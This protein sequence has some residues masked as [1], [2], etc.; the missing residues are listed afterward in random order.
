MYAYNASPAQVSFVKKLLAER[1]VSG[2]N[3]AYAKR[4]TE[5]LRGEGEPLTKAGAH[6]L[7]EGLLTLPKLGGDTEVQTDTPDVP[8]GFYAVRGTDPEAVNDIQF[9]TIDK[10]TEG[11]WAGYTFV[12][13]VVG[14][15]EIRI[16][17]SRQDAAVAAIAK[18][19]KAASILYGHEIGRCGLCNRRLTNQSSREA[20]IGPVCAS[21]A[22]W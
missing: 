5:I 21:K 10:P 18:D 19:P 12:N 22:G 7:I 14:Q 13:Q 1:D 6:T 16:S 9:F 17:R 8:A 11:R 15:E 20:G 4:C 2:F 3:A